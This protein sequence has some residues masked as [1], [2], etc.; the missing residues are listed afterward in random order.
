MELFIHRIDSRAFLIIG[1]ETIEIKDYKISSSMH[2][3]TELEIILNV[4]GDIT[5][6]SMSTN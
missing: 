2:G 6:F 3:S 5:E 4:D 1:K